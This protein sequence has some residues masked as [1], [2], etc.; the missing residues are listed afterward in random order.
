ML[1]DL[2][3]GLMRLRVLGVKEEL[4][5]SLL[6]TFVPGIDIDILGG[7]GMDSTAFANNLKGLS[8]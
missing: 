1:R 4:I 3:D 7:D 5:Q 2:A 8:I 6:A